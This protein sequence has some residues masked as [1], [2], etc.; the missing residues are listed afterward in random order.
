M[1]TK[2]AFFTSSKVY[3]PTWPNRL[4]PLLVGAGVVIFIW[5]SIFFTARQPGP[6]LPAAFFLGFAIIS[7][8]LLLFSGL[9]CRGT[10]GVYLLTAPEGLL[11]QSMGFFVYTPWNNVG[12]V[13][14]LMVGVRSIEHLSLK[15]EPLTEMDLE[16]GIQEQVA[17]LHTASALRIAEDA[18]PALNLLATISTSQ[19]GRYGTMASQTARSTLIPVG[20]FGAQWKTGELGDEIRRYTT[21]ETY[22]RLREQA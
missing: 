4:S 6:V 2:E 17:L 18:Q 11:Y 3:R 15:R 5:V 19:R 12:D 22:A 13:K 21:A 7:L 8:G 20:I 9:L 14:T 16:E 1:K 10:L